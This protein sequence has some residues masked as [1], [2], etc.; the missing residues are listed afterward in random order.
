MTG[1]FHA[2]APAL[3]DEPKTRNRLK[4]ADA[5][6]AAITRAIAYQTACL[7][8]LGEAQAEPLLILVRDSETHHVSAFK[9]VTIAAPERACRICGCTH[10]TPCAGGC[11]WA[12]ADLC[13]ACDQLM[14]GEDA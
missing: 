4:R 6:Q 7:R 14:K 2:W 10:E 13:T 12:G 9:V 3:E 5:S 1:K 8:E 11:G